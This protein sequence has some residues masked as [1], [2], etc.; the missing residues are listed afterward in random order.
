[1][2]FKYWVDNRD[3]RDKYYKGPLI[4][5][6]DETNFRHCKIVGKISQL[7]ALKNIKGILTYDLESLKSIID[8]QKLYL[9]ELEECDEELTFKEFHHPKFYEIIEKFINDGDKF[10]LI[11]EIQPLDKVKLKSIYINQCN[12]FW[13]EG[14]PFN[15]QID[16]HNMQSLSE[17]YFKEIYIRHKKEVGWFWNKDHLKYNKRKSTAFPYY[18]LEEVE[19]AYKNCE[20]RLKEIENGF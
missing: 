15:F 18:S 19:E 8:R 10:Y 20:I 7:E 1:M 11:G 6:Y 16:L 2:L 13:Q 14:K 5:P 17:R 9:N 12:E 3:I 4:I